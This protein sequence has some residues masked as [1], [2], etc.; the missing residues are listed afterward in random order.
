[1]RSEIQVVDPAAGQAEVEALLGSLAA[2]GVPATL[3]EFPGGARAVVVPDPP[4]GLARPASVVRRSTVEVPEASLVTRR[5]FLD[6]FAA[7]LAAATVGTG[8]VFAGIFAAPPEERRETV[9]ETRRTAGRSA[10]KQATRRP[11]RVGTRR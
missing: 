6:S 11:P 1:M 4:A 3:R 10:S 5:N 2:R 8:A 9:E 7:G